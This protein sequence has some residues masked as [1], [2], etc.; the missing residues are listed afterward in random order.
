MTTIERPEYKVIGTR[1]IRPDGAEKVTGKAQYGA[2][3]HLPGLIQGRILRSPHAHAKI[4][5]V[6]TSE[7]E[8]HPGVLAVITA[9]D[10]PG[11]EDKVEELGESAINL[12]D[13][14]DNIL[15][16]DKALYRGHAIAAVAALNG[17]IAEEAMAKIKV[18]YEVLPPVMN[19]RDA[20][21]DD[22]PLL[23]ENRHT[24]T[25]MTGEMSEKPS[26]IASYNKFAG[27]DL[28]AAFAEADVVVEREFTTAMVHQGYLEPHNSTANWNSDDTITIWT[29]TQGAFA[30]R[31]LTAD[32]LKHPIASIKVVPMEIGGGF[33]G[34]LPIYLDP[35]A[36]LLSK[37]SGR[38]VKVLMSRTDVFEGS[39][40]TSGTY[41]K[42]KAAAKG[43]R[44]TAVQ[45]T[46]C[47]E[48]GAFPGSSVGAG[49]MTMLSPYNIDSFEINAY[50]VVVNRPKTAAYRA[51]GAPAAAFAI[52]SVIDEIC[53]KQGLDPLDFRKENASKE[54][55]RMVNGV[56]FPRIGAEETV[57]AAIDSPHWKSPIEGPNRGRGVASGYWFNGGMQSSVVANVNNDG[58]VNLV[59]GSTDIGGTRASL[60]MQ[61]AETLGVD[62][63]TIRPTV[64][65]TDSIGH[66]DVTGGSRTT[67]A[68]GLAV[69]EAG[70]DIRRQMIARAA[71]MWGVPDEEVVYESG[72][73][74]SLKDSTKELTFKDMAA[75]SARTGGPIAGKASLLARGAGGAFA[76]H[77]VDVEVDPD[78]GKVTILRYTATQDVGTAIHPSYV[79]GQIQG[80]VVQGIGWALNEEYYYD[81]DG[82][83][84]NSSF[85]DYRMPTALDV[86]MIDTVLVEVPNP[87]H[88][89]G[90]RGVGEVPIVPPLA[91]IANAIADATGHRFTDLPMSPRRIVET[92]NGLE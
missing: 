27:G 87:G 17:H 50:D 19:V 55:T 41:I 71:K 67:F 78:T 16:S 47:Y 37:K 33:G 52:E 10:F 73:L 92:L 49:S 34:K 12:K 43:N 9:K 22:A 5:S 39:G 48:A 15:A 83:M 69:F 66:N 90:V 38:P 59:E 76:T 85:L 56:A 24:K 6:D 14:L 20:M 75:Q 58:T 81:E 46:L 61:L 72:R 1:P 21:R 7:A 29:S 42:L 31:N 63:E 60:A 30:V 82:R 44:L 84:V 3:I 32:V 79:E 88:P 4:L 26:N 54:G 45:A 53:K 23:N 11:A 2:D 35:V 89:Y 77:I 80:G 64:V 86:P 36:A 13:A 51:P 8:K 91:A 18:Q 70:M 40:P 65:D 25:L 62:Y 28:D 57:Q 74:H 68:S